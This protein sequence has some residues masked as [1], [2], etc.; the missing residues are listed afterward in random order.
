MEKITKENAVPNY[1]EKFIKKSWTWARLTEKEKEVF[2]QK[3][4]DNHFDFGYLTNEYNLYLEG[5]GCTSLDWRE[6]KDLKQKAIEAAEYLNTHNK[7]L[8]KK[9]EYAVWD[10]LEYLKTV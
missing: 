6:E 2:S 1:F 5:L 7:N 3:V 9:Q 4:V 8:T 10:I